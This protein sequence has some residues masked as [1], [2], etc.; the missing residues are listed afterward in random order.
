ME[1]PPVENAAVRDCL[2]LL[3]DLNRDLY[4]TC[5]LLPARRRAPA[6][7]VAT[8]FCELAAIADR[9][10]DPMAAL[11]RFAWW[12][13]GLRALNGV[14]LE[15]SPIYRPPRASDSPILQTLENSIAGGELSPAELADLIADQQSLYTADYIEDDTATGNPGEYGVDACMATARTMGGRLLALMAAGTSAAQIDPAQS[16]R[17]AIGGAWI[18][19]EALRSAAAGRPD[20]MVALPSVVRGG[21]RVAAAA[22]VRDISALCRDALDAARASR[23]H[24]SRSDRRVLMLGRLVDGYLRQFKQVD[25][26]VARCPPKSPLRSV[27]MLRGVVSGRY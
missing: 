3:R 14:H 10:L 12:Q 25:F 2:A 26:D 1:Q 27:T 17:A 7:G 23:R 21:D 13:D 24:L 18:L 22:G 4:V 11:V 19:C 9:A 8:L 5:L 6:I 20:G 15:A 16:S